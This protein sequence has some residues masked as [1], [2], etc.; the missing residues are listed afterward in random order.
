MGS[1]YASLHIDSLT[2]LL[3]ADREQ[4]LQCVRDRGWVLD[5]A[6]GLVAPRAATAAPRVL[7]PDQRQMQQLVKTAVELENTIA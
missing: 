2:S 6:T 5:E 1:T 4:T 7:P 3:A